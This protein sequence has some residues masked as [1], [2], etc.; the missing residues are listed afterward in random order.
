VL[1][2]L[3]SFLTQFW[4]ALIPWVVLDSEQVGFIRHLGIPRKALAP[5]WTWKIPL[6]QT[7]EVEDGRAYPQI[8][9]PQSLRTVD[10]VQVV[11]RISVTCRV[12]DAEKYFLSVYDGRS[13]IQD[14]ACGE[15]A[16]IVQGS[17]ADDV[18]SGA[19]LKPV[20]KKVRAVAAK[21]GMRVDAVKF[22]DASESTSYRL[23]Q[24]QLTAAGQE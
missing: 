3:F 7:A 18:Q 5:G 6:V 22:I 19:V 9:D 10:G 1:S 11:V 12:V 20:L 24:S 4:R 16:D 17:T 13:N 2:Q 21:W 8:L 15:L 14:A 23:W